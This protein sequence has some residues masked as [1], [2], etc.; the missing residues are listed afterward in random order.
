MSETDIVR[1]L[2]VLFDRKLTF[3]PHMEHIIAKA[4]RMVGF[5][6]R[7]AREFR[8]AKTKKILYG[9]LVRSILEYGSVIWRPHYATHSLRIE[10][11]QKRFLRHLA[12]SVGMGGR[13][14]SYEAHLE[15]FNMIKL[16][17]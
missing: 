5:I 4:S 15:S 3:V 12:Y 7:N 13:R 9:C 14:V 10:R 11:I 2:G 17:K 6:V 16:S 8:K 1:D